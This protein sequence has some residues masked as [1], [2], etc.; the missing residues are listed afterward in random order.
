M[1]RGHRDR[2]RTYGCILAGFRAT[3]LEGDSVTLVLEALWSDKT[4]NARSLGVRFGALLLWLDF[5]ANDELAD[6][7]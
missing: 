5:T 4:L 2:R 1:H 3:A 6:L 7:Y